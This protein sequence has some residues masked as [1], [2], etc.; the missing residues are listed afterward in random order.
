MSEYNDIYLEPECCADPDTGRMWCQ[1]PINDCDEGVEWTHYVLGDSVTGQLAE[2]QAVAKR[3]KV[4]LEDATYHDGRYD[5]H[6][7]AAWQKEAC[8]VVKA[9]KEVDD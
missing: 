4:L 9:I 3:A 8:A 5:Q 6:T 7:D 2:L 1:D